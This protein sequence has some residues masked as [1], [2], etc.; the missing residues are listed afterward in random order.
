MHSLQISVSPKFWIFWQG[1][2]WAIED[3]FNVIAA[4]TSR[5]LEAIGGIING[6]DLIAYQFVPN[7]VV[8]A[9]PQLGA[10]VFIMHAGIVA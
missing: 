1:F 8:M 3:I 7:R 4:F 9:M 5:V 10:I 6:S 2:A